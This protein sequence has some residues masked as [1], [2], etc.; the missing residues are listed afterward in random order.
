MPEIERHPKP[1]GAKG[2]NRQQQQEHPDSTSFTA[3][4]LAG[5]EIRPPG[6]VVSGVVLRTVYKLAEYD[7]TSNAFQRISLF[8]AAS[9][10][11]AH[12]T[13]FDRTG[14]GPRSP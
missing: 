7:A 13:F 6:G 9:G 14:Q 12:L 5:Y 3:D 11:S 1:V 10:T 4:I 2:D 8:K